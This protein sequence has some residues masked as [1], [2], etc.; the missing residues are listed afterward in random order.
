MTFIETQTK[1]A[2]P[3]ITRPNL[4]SL[5]NRA[6]RLMQARPLLVMATILGTGMLIGS[7][8]WSGLGRLWR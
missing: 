8:M 6:M 3:V 7:S 1:K 2:A 4:Q 5:A